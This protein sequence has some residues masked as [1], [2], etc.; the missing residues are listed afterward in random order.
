MSKKAH[1]IGICGV[2]M[3]AAAAL[4]RELGYIVTGSA[5]S[6]YPPVRTYLEEHNLLTF[7]DHKRSNIPDDVDLVVAGA[8]AALD[9]T[10]NE[11][12]DEAHVRDVSVKTFPE[13]LDDI[14]RGKENIVVA[15]SY[16]KTTCTTLIAW[17]LHH[18]G[19]DPG[20]FIGALVPQLPSHGHLGTS[21]TF[22]LEGDEYPTSGI[23]NRSKFLLFPTH[24]VLL[25]SADHDHVNKYPTHESYI[26]P[27]KKLLARIP[28][29]GALVACSDNLPV[30]S[31]IHHFDGT[32]VR[33]GI[34]TQHHPDWSATNIIYNKQ[35]T[36]D[37][38]HKGK[39]VTSMETELLGQHNVLNIVGAAAIVLEKG[40]LTPEEVQKAV[41]AFK[42]VTRR[43][44]SK[45]DKSTVEV[46]EGF[47]S[48]REKAIAAIDAMRA[49]FKDKRLLVIFEPHTFS[50]R[51]KNKL[52][53]YDDTFLEADKVC[54]YHPPEIGVGNHE[55]AT[56]A[57]IVDRIQKSGV[58]A[59][60]INTEQEGLDLLKAELKSDDVV[61]MLTSGNLDGLVQSIPLL[62][63]KL[64]PKK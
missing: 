32:C 56:H 26:E 45:T 22:V 25:T 59:I 8:S 27:F 55:Q 58:H 28:E 50:W 6:C 23:D 63:E 12:V 62:A 44:D 4:L 17:M 11:E 40:L 29:D 49:H 15:G 48:S 34:D 57:E 53:W 20:Y 21:T 30:R 18:A 52:S 19:C 47:G 37:L 24:D 39:V 31:L 38:V 42:G 2:G 51:N 9:R 35:T 54:V 46:Y 14:T 41:A 7:E 60:P 43:L 36:F 5:T 33:Y 61:L 1:F 3:S 13:V 64:F 10:Q 16:G